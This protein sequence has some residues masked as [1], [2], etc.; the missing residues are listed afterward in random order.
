M[1]SDSEEEEVVL[2]PRRRAAAPEQPAASEDAGAE[3]AADAPSEAAPR[4]GRL[5]RRGEVEAAAQGEA[6]RGGWERPR[7]LTLAGCRGR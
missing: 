6:R 2:L 5:K 1:E 4:P 7:A 3:A